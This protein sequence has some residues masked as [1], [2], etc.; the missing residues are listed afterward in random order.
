MST[1]RKARPDGDASE[2]AR[3]EKHYASNNSRSHFITEP[4]LISISG[5][6]KE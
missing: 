2:Q 5:R 1:K 4:V 3:Q 6:R